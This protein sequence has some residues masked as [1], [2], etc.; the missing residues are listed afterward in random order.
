MA[1][2]HFLTYIK[3]TFLNIKLIKTRM[4]ELSFTFLAFKYKCHTVHGN[5]L[6]INYVELHTVSVNMQHLP[7]MALPLSFRLSLQ[8]PSSVH[9]STQSLGTSSGWWQVPFF[10]TG[11][12]HVHIFPSKLLSIWAK[13]F[14]I[15]VNMPR[16]ALTPGTAETIPACREEVGKKM[17]LPKDLER[18]RSGAENQSVRNNNWMV[19]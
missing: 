6:L 4:R 8:V 13:F 15:P 5:L 17:A 12:V 16:K 14:S 9:P 10:E 11:L 7:I 3:L 2:T 1:K 18:R 19:A